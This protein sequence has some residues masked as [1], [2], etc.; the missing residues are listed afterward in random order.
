MIEKLVTSIIEMQL[1]I[2]TIQKDDMKIYQYGYTLLI[3]VLINIVLSFIVSILLG[4][5]K[6]CIFFMCAFVP[7]RSFCG[8][9]HAKKAWK[10]IALS[11]I[12]I[13]SAILFADF[14]ARFNISLIWFLA[15]EV[16]LGIIIMHLSPVESCNNR[17]TDVQRRLYKKY[18][19]VILLIEMLV[20]NVFLI[21][22]YQK[23]FN[24]VLGV[25]IVQTISLIVE[26]SFEINNAT[27]NL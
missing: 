9:Y 15:G 13:M 22:G 19:R 3:E 11:N 1:R 12:S 7:L 23:I 14:I 27:I 18:A 4:I 2:G 24:L 26:T 20:G 16:I 10:C 17:L 6:E 21:L 8:G 25:H 5:L